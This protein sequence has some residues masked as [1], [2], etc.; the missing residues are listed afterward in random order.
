[1]GCHVLCDD[2]LGRCMAICVYIIM[3]L[4]NFDV[5]F[6]ILRPKLGTDQETTAI[7]EYVVYSIFWLLMVS[8]HLRTMCADPGFVSKGYQFREEVIAAPF[9]TLEALENAF[10]IKDQNV[11]TFRVD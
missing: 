3:L 5:F 9:K 2:G 6:V 11:S 7:A 10:L 8:S 1:M 4:G